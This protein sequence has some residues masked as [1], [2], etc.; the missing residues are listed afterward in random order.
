[1]AQYTVIV[2]KAW[3]GDDQHWVR[4][5]LADMISPLEIKCSQSY[6]VEVRLCINLQMD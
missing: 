3:G 1:M 5:R 6:T 2:W 4:G